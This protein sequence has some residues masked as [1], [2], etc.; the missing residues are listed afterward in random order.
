ML[1]RVFFISK[2]TMKLYE[3]RKIKGLLILL[4]GL[5]IVAMVKLF[6]LPNHGVINNL[7]QIEV[8]TDTIWQ[9]QVDTLRLQTTTY[10]QIYLTVHDTIEKEI[11]IDSVLVNMY[12]DTLHT[13]DISI[14]SKQFISGALIKGELNY[15]LHIPKE[16]VKT[17]TAYIPMHPRSNLSI[18]A[19][20]GGLVTGNQNLGVGLIYNNKN[21]WLVTG[22]I[23]TLPVHKPSYHFGI[24]YRLL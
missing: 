22:R 10:E 3:L 13:N 23:N 15:K 19:E 14:Y 16:I 6:S 11:R 18:Y 7:P 8:K 9:T 21:R 24:G 4:I 20:V 5:T 1:R 17:Q 12:L 2:Y